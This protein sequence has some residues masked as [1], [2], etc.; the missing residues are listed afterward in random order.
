MTSKILNSPLREE[1]IAKLIAGIS[2][3]K[4]HEWIKIQYPND[5]SQHITVATLSSFRKNY[6]NIDRDAARVIKEERK[7]KKLGLPHN[8]N[9][10]SFM[11]KPGE[12]TTSKS[13]VMKV[14]E[15]LLQSPTYKERLREIAD[16][17]LDAPRK[18]MELHKLLESRIE[19]YYNTV[20]SNPTPEETLKADKMLVDFMRLATDVLK[21]SK[22]V[23]N[24][25]NAQP[26][27]G[28]VDLNVVNEQI[29]LVRE[30]VVD[31]FKELDPAMALEFVDRLNKKIAA[32]E[33][34]PVRAP[35]VLNRVEKL[36]Q[37]IEEIKERSHE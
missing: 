26:D 25:Y 30:T 4:V 13:Y 1:I 22:K 8:E 9:V 27:E 37:Q 32:L 35:E 15:N 12:D 10:G 36:T 18:M 16:A 29:D 11:E 14:R 19:V 20:S 3:N 5:P 31:M 6:L 2:P 33:Y 23:W 17:Q 7:K 34:K 24:D 21:D 28:T